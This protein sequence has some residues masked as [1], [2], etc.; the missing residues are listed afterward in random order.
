MKNGPRETTSL[1]YVT[2]GHLSHCRGFEKSQVD[3]NITSQIIKLLVTNSVYI[4][5]KSSI[6]ISN[7]SAR[8]LHNPIKMAKKT[9]TF[10]QIVKK[11]TWVETN[12]QIKMKWFA[13]AHGKLIENDV[14]LNISI[15]AQIYNNKYN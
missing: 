15:R 8:S 1:C 4:Y 2:K 13:V 7:I 9:N 12:C 3:F 14:H 11:L 5:H 10:N 6:Y